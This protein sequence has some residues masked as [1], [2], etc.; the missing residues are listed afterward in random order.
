M[1]MR[2]PSATLQNDVLLIMFSMPRNSESSL[3]ER[4]VRNR[5]VFSWSVI[6]ETME[7]KPAQLV[8][9]IICEALRFVRDRSA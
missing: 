1:G 8:L 4:N 9:V 5:F 2:S 3:E 6:M 7:D